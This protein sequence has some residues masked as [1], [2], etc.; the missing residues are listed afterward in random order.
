MTDAPERIWLLPEFAAENFASLPGSPYDDRL[1][2]EYIAA[3]KVQELIRAAVES[4]RE[5]CA[6]LM[7]RALDAL[8]SGAFDA[9]DPRIDAVA[10]YIDAIRGPKP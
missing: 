2:S 1:F 7:A 10:E 9:T 8:T 5:R 3:P 4:E 6:D